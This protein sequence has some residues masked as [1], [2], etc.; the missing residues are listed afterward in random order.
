MGFFG[1][2]L[3]W[4][5]TLGAVNAVL[6]SHLIEKSSADE[7]KEIAREIV[8]I[9]SSVQSG[10]TAD[11]ILM[12]L[13]AESRVVQTNFIALACDNLG[14]APPVRNNVWTRVENPYRTASQIDATRIDAA[15]SAV[16]KQDGVRLT[17]PGSDRR[18]NFYSMYH[19]GSLG[20][21]KSSEPVFE[22]DRLVKC[23]RC[24]RSFT[25]GDANWIADTICRCPHCQHACNV[26]GVKKPY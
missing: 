26:P 13:S 17:W 18:I 16:A 14:I 7:R 25:L 22:W 23:S 24:G 6:A 5:Q 11:Q 3:G 15:L 19:R 21:S 20:E 9:V 4:D 8:R 1:S 10:L 12:N 2:L